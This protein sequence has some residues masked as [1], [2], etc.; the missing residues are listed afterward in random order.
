MLHHAIFSKDT[1]LVPRVSHMAVHV[2]QAL[3]SSKAHLGCWKAL[4]QTV[5]DKGTP[6]PADTSS[7]WHELIQHSALLRTAVATA[8]LQ[9]TATQLWGCAPFTP[10]AKL[11]VP[12]SHTLSWGRWRCPGI[13][14]L[15]QCFSTCHLQTTPMS[16]TKDNWRK[17]AC[18]YR[19]PLAPLRLL[20]IQI[21][22]ETAL[23]G[24]KNTQET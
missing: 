23:H 2:P 7:P 12:R 15:H 16:S 18:S 6:V 11:E 5:W 24:V 9:E 4:V 22:L 8:E 10:S 21:Q 13:I 1:E 20:G 14:S 3:N 19:Q 17:P